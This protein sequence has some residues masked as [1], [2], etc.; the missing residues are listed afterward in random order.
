APTSIKVWN[1]EAVGCKHSTFLSSSMDPVLAILPHRWSRD[2]WSLPHPARCAV[3]RA[4][5][6][7]LVRLCKARSSASGVVHRLSAH[8][9]LGQKQLSATATPINQYF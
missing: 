1:S 5:S 2:S 8:P 4:K 9:L 3:S 7:S 6:T